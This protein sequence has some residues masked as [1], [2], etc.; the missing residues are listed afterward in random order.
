VHRNGGFDPI[1]LTAPRAWIRA[2]ADGRFREYVGRSLE[3]GACVPA[4]SGLD[5]C[6]RRASGGDTDDGVDLKLASR[7][8][9]EFVFSLMGGV[10]S[11]CWWLFEGMFRRRRGPLVWAFSGGSLGV[12]ARARAPGLDLWCQLVPG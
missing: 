8:A 1:H 2:P 7:E 11:H 10:V 5:N 9:G 3:K 4:G 6:L 12:W